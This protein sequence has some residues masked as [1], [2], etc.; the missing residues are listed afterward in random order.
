[1]ISRQWFI[2]KITEKLPRSFILNEQGYGEA[3]VNIALCKYWGKRCDILNL[4]QTSSLSVSIPTLRAQTT[5]EVSSNIDQIYLNNFLIDYKSSFY[6]QVK[7]FLDNF[8]FDRSLFFKIKTEMNIPH[9]AGL[10]SSACG[11][12]ALTQALNNLFN[13]QLSSKELSMIARLGSGSAARSIN[14]G[15]VLWHRGVQNDGFDSYAELLNH[16]LPSMRLGLMI[17]DENQKEISSREA[18]KKTVKESRLYS[19]WSFI[20]E[21]DLNNILQAFKRS[22]SEFV[23]QIA[24]RNCLAMHAT[25]LDLAE[26][27]IYDSEQTV[28]LKKKIWS[29]RKKGIPIYFTQDAGP[30]L[31]LLFDEN[32]SEI[33]LDEFPCIQIHKIFE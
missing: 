17:L 31:K 27:I 6:S 14:K 32:M 22:D 15:L 26:P 3:P 33:V 2:K 24:E 5:V 25:M 13:W 21:E 20:V 12:A 30:N 28:R 23:Y 19:N 29:L 4:P 10:A 11:F 9:S 7:I 8:R 18:M 1:M 16:Q